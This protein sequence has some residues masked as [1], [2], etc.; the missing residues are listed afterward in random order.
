MSLNFSLFAGSPSGG[1]VPADGAGTAARLVSPSPQPC[2]DADGT[3]YFFDGISASQL[4]K[5]TAAGVVSTIAGDPDVSGF[6]DGTGAAARFLSTPGGGFAHLVVDGDGTVF[7]SDGAASGTGELNCI[8]K[9]TPAG[10]VTTIAGTNG[11]AAAAVDGVGAAARFVSIRGMCLGPDGNLYVTDKH[12]LRLVTRG[13]LV[14]TFAGNVTT[15][16]ETNA[17]GTAARFRNPGG[18]AWASDGNLYVH[19][20]NVG[21]TVGVLRKVTAAGVVT[22]PAMTGTALPTAIRD[23]CVETGGFLSLSLSGVNTRYTISAA[24]A[25]TTDDP[26]TAFEAAG[27]QVFSNYLQVPGGSRWYVFGVDA[28]TSAEALYSTEPAVVDGASLE[29]QGDDLGTSCLT[30]STRIV[31]QALVEIGIT[32]PIV[33]LA[34]EQTPA[35]VTARLFYADA[36]LEVLRAFTWPFATRYATLVL[37]DGTD[38]EAV[39][40]DWQYS[41]RLPAD[42]V[43]ARRLVNPDGSKRAFDPNP[44][45]FRLGSDDDRLLYTD[46]A[47]DTDTNAPELE[48]TFRPDCAARAGDA[49]FRRALKWLLASHLAPSLEKTKITQAECWAAFQAALTDAKVPAANEQQAP[50]STGDAEWITGR[51]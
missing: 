3:I 15:A 40:G 34:T 35:A 6:V 41:Y 32:K 31:N 50:A 30:A 13:G 16:G 7:V 19:T 24:L 25:V 49:L 44:P 29:P 12:G 39:N 10:V 22:T 14:L 20:D 17:T 28:S 11:V 1:T 48:Y 37:V 21:S 2:A 26:W 46:V 8:R 45:K 33:N 23:L 43:F 36:V 42:C 51:N 47:V 38:T 9:V 27:G 5:C 4:K 18:L